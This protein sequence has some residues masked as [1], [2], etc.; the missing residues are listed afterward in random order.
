[1]VGLC[2]GVPVLWVDGRYVEGLYVVGSVGG[3]VPGEEVRI[4]GADVGSFDGN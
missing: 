4:L 2:D 3:D 1:M